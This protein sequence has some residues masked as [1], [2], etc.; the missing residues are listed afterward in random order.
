MCVP[1][2]KHCRNFFK[3]FGSFLKL[4]E[5]SLEKNK[6]NCE[7]LKKKNI[8]VEGTI[9]T[10]ASNSAWQASYLQCKFQNFQAPHLCT[11]EKFLVFK[12]ERQFHQTLFFLPVCAGSEWKDS[13]ILGTSVTRA[14][15]LNADARR[16]IYESAR[17]KI[18]G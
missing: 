10:L 7:F 17:K 4:R 13:E 2:K 15:T 3:A 5:P 1:G 6:I 14:C 9:R 18:S 16:I 12:K 11:A 8:C